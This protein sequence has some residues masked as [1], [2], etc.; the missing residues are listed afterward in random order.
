MTPIDLQLPTLTIR[1][2]LFDHYPDVVELD[3]D[4]LEVEL[5]NG[6]TVAVGWFPECDPTGHFVVTTFRRYWTDKVG[7]PL[8]AKTPQDAA[9]IVRRIA[10]EASRSVP[11]VNE[12][13]LS[14]T[15]IAN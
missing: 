8:T 9:D 4:I 11:S 5:P 3:Q 10:E 14:D 13:L 15:A 12:Q 1:G 6:L 7:D 2:Q